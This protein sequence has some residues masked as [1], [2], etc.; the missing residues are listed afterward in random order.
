MKNTQKVKYSGLNYKEIYG[1]YIDTQ[2]GVHN[3]QNDY[4]SI[5]WKVTIIND[6]EAGIKPNSIYEI[7]DKPFELKAVSIKCFDAQ[8]H[9]L[10]GGCA[11]DSS[12]T[13]I[14]G[15]KEMYIK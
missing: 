8:G 11:I 4:D 10:S 2:D 6:G 14:E 1:S 7:I 15:N 3:L 12:T 5:I 13:K 9:E